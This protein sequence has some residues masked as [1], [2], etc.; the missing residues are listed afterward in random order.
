MA[1]NSGP[2]QQKKTHSRR[3]HDAGPAG[4]GTA[5]DVDA[6]TYYQV[7]NVSMTASRAEITSA[8][9]QAMRQWHPDRVAP[10]RREAAEATAKTINAAYATLSDPAK[11]LAYDGTIRSQ[12]VQDQVMK[13]YVGGFGGPGIGGQDPFALGLKREM[14][15]AEKRDRQ[16][17][18][19]SAIITVFSVFLVVS[20]GAIGLLILFALISWVFSYFV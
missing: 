14:T 2:S 11:R 4:R 8:Y 10:Q 5:R 13:R 6:E 18:E 20:L 1:S 9:R 7:L 17:S 12:E 3:A 15:G 16:R 19:R